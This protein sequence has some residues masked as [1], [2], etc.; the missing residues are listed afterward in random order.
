M[1]KETTPTHDDTHVPDDELVELA[2]G[3]LES[4]RRD[5][6]LD[7]VRSCPDCEH[8]FQR[9]VGEYARVLSRTRDQSTPRERIVGTHDPSLGRSGRWKRALLLLPVAAVFAIALLRPGTD[10]VTLNP[11]ESSFWIPTD[12]EIMHLRRPGV[13]QALEARKERA[14]EA[15]D[16]HDWSTALIELEKMGVG[17]SW[18]DPLPIYLADCLVRAGRAEDAITMISRLSAGLL[19]APWRQYTHWIL[20]RAYR[21]RGFED[22]ARE[23]LRRVADD[24]GELGETAAQALSHP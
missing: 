6:V 1:T 9:E 16:S 18:N 13:D 7:H 4:P 10:V 19:P 12:L 2:Y 11:E 21:D 22:E 5:R 17:P 23:A 14:L 8:R 3:V 15:Y 24:G 20:Y